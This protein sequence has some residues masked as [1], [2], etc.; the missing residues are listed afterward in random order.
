MKR[1]TLVSLVVMVLLVWAGGS[2]AAD[3]VGSDACFRC[4]PDQYNDFKVSGHPYKLSKAEDARKRLIPLPAG[5]SWDDIS[6][7]I[8]GAYKKARYIDLNGYIITA[9]KD[10]SELKTQYNMETGGWAFYHKGEKKPYDCGRCHTTGYQ[11]EGHQDG[12]EGLIGTWAAPGVQ[13]EACHGPGGGHI[14]TGNKTEIS[15]DKSS[16]LCGGCHLRGPKEKI[17]AKGG[18]IKHHEQYP[19]LLASPH[20]G[21]SCVTCHNPH[22]RAEFSIKNE[23]SS[24][25][26]SQ[27][28]TF[29]GSTMEQVGVKCIDCHMPRLVKSAVAR[30]KFEAD[31][32][33]HLF[34]INTEKGADMFYTVEEDGKKHTYA[35]NFITPDYACLS[36]HK[37]KDKKWAEAE[38]E[39]IHGYGK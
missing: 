18:F 36:C 3:Y 19:E 8:G 1:L 23:C 33:T 39:G 35:R 4:H 30:G 15:V 6:Y 32:R 34:R 24:C 26:A 37:N 25:H 7:V 20:K 38:A 14:K 11:K 27:A 13:C 21:F 31:I 5:Y 29:K 17:P 9:A 12:R 2:F 28:A 16:A 22:K 10:G